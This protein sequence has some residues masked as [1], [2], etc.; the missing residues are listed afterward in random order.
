MIPVILNVLV[1]MQS[2]DSV[3]ISTTY[4]IRS[5][6]RGK[7]FHIFYKAVNCPLISLYHLHN[8]KEL[9]EKDYNYNNQHINMIVLAIIA[10]PKKQ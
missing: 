6:N 1:C 5:Y 9:S 7:I 10:L 8:F 3:Q 2:D 4:A